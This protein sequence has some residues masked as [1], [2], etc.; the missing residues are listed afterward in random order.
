MELPGPEALRAG[1][2]AL[3]PVERK[4]LGG[5]IVLM[6]HHHDRVKHREWIAENFT[7]IAVA[8]LGFDQEGE[9][10]AD[11]A[12][13]QA[14]VDASMGRVLDLAFPLFRQIAVEMLAG[15]R[16]DKKTAYEL[17]LGYLGS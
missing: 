5:M 3:E 6:I 11:V 1:I 14:F 7:R 13:V 16:P 8:A 10:D 4:V 12:A 17:A 9:V 15:G 2:Q